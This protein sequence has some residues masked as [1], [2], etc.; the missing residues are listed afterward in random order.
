MN[1]HFR[2]IKAGCCLNNASD[3]ILNSFCNIY[4]VAAVGNVDDCIGNDPVVIKADSDTL[5]D[6]FQADQFG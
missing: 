6:R 3:R 5:G 4:D 2:I 1:V